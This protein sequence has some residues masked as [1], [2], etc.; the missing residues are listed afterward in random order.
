MGILSVLVVAHVGCG[1]SGDDE[2]S[3]GASG[4]GG[5]L[6]TGTG[7]G[8]QGDGGAAS[9]GGTGTGGT[10]T[11]GDVGATGGASSGGGEGSGG[12]A[13]GGAPPVLEC[14]PPPA[15]SDVYSVD[16]RGITLP[17][18]SG[19]LRLDVCQDDVMRVRYASNEGA[20]SAELPEKNSLV[21]NREWPVPQFCVEELDGN[22]VLTTF[23]M[24]TS[25]ELESG[26]VSYL[27][28]DEELVLSESGKS[29]TDAELAGEATKSV[30]TIFDS[31]E[32]EG[33]FGLGQ[34]QDGVS[35]RKGRNRRLENNN[36][37]IALPFLT[38]SRGYGLLWDN[39]SRS[40]FY[41]GE[42]QNT[43]FRYVSQA[44]DLVD[45]YFFYGPSMDEVIRGYRTATGA[46]PMFPKWAYGLFHSK[47]HYQNQAELLAVKD[48]YRD[49]DIPLDAIVQDWRYWA[50]YAWGSHYFDEDRYPDPQA[51]VDEMHA[52]NVHTM[53]S[54]WP[55]YQTQP[56]LKEGE[57][58]NFDALDAIGAILPSNGEHHFYDVFNEEARALVYQQTYDRLLGLYG[59]DALWADNTE[60]QGYP[61]GFDWNTWDTAL[62][63]A[64]FY[65]NAYPLGHS[66][67]LYENWR[68][69]GPDEKRVYVLTRSA[70]AGQQRYATTCWSGDIDC[71]FPTYERQIPAGLNFTISGI[72]YWTTDIGGY[73]GHPERFD[74]TTTEANELFTRWFQ[75]GAFCPIFRI[76]GGGSRELYSDSWTATTKANLLVID[77]LRYRLMPYVYSLA[78][79]VTSES[80][81]MMRHLVFD[82]PADENVYDIPD[83]FLFGPS[84]LVNPITEAGATS[85]G[86]YFPAGTWYDFWEG[87]TVSGGVEQ[88]VPAPLSRIPL[89]VKAGSILPMGPEIQYAT[90]SVDPIELRIYPGQ[91]AT[92]VLYEDANDTY[93]Y[94]QGEYATIP[95]SWNEA[96]RD[97]T[98]GARQGSFP[99]MLASRTF[100]VVIVGEG[101]GAGPGVTADPDLTITYDGIETVVSAP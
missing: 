46:A 99:G 80:Y 42:D 90:E 36:T 41:G 33:L 86:V 82:Y 75:Y 6:S 32:N 30:E 71:D 35:N 52:D 96:T 77:K 88:D 50:P 4:S 84:L 54:V 72:P 23:R 100:H 37:D 68:S 57:A 16:E 97:L 25:I 58:D 60:P 48:G 28:L 14:P 79:Q 15:P 29:L 70:F 101:H 91:D 38:S 53:I 3:S 66:Q 1:H 64:L 98:I 62:G 22:V 55:V 44:G 95:F 13:S 10:G 63:G 74:W 83:Q 45:Y 7:G 56:E 69:I 20:A 73:W 9:S 65:R 19:V 93:A 24:K 8:V 51:L 85:R 94:E 21:V 17:T 5:S 59:W 89:F 26:L 47:D 43:K 49:A 76:H 67:A 12:A 61:D 31:P 18:N 87:S 40:D 11:G 34:P 92:F 81:T 2:G 27:T 39:T 78:W